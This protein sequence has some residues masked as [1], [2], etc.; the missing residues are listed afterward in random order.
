MIGVE[1]EERDGVG[2]RVLWLDRPDK[3]NALTPGMLAQLI[4]E[5]EQAAS[6]GD[7]VVVAGRGKAFC[8]G[9]DL[10]M[11]QS[12]PDGAIM[13]L[14]LTGLSDACRALRT[15]NRPVV[16]AVHGAAIAGGCAL[17]GGADVVVADRRALLGYPVVK[18]GVSPAV[19]VPFLRQ[20][21][22]DGTARARALLPETFSAA[23]AAR[24]GL[25]HRLVDHPDGV[26]EAAKDEAFR[27]A[28]LPD[29][30]YAATKQWLNT[31]EGVFKRR[32][33]ERG[34]EVS[35]GLTGGREERAR[36]GAL[37]FNAP[38]PRTNGDTR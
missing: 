25:V 27:L 23:E 21:V 38:E 2:V 16:L 17:L 31:L 10:A 12:A 6:Q 22:T 18:L 19:S 9:F 34:L 32:E 13:R 28:A 14:L 4:G 29:A 7:G 33:D 8:S 24:H 36:L 3:R 35:L 5:A 30:A 1:R 11:C 26:L 15:L 37:E 20:S